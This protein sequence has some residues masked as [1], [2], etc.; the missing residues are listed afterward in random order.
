MP[1]PD[2]T[3]PLFGESEFPP[4][5]PPPPPA[6][7]AAPAAAPAR[8]TAPLAERMRPRALDE[9]LGQARLIGPEGTLRRL[10][11]AG[12]LPSLILHGPPGS[13]K[14]TLARLLAEASDASFVAFSAVSEGVPRLREIV[15]EA[16]ARRR[17]G[18]RT[19]IFVDEIHRLNKGQQ[20]FL[21]PF[22]ESG[23]LTLIG[24]TTEHPAFEVL[25]QVFGCVGP[26][27]VLFSVSQDG[28][29][30]DF[31]RQSADDSRPLRAAA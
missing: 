8:G 2:D 5:P 7:A 3:L 13:G 11:E 12:Y 30:S 16:E 4:P 6:P 14:T 27:C 26:L 28:Q 1:E 24:A 15:K 21:L 17:S 22:V 19:L 9:V 10:L 29:V 25:S 20:D 23:L 31:R 18:G